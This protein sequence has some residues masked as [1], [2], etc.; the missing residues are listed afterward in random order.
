MDRAALSPGMLWALRWPLA[1]LAVG[2]ALVWPGWPWWLLM[3]LTLVAEPLAWAWAGRTDEDDVPSRQTAIL[4]A[5]A[6][7]FASLGGGAVLGAW[8]N[9]LMGAPWSVRLGW[10]VLAVIGGWLIAQGPARGPG[11]TAG[12]A[13]LSAAVY[14]SAF[15]AGAALGQGA[16]GVFWAALHGS[17]LAL[18]WGWAVSAATWSARQMAPLSQPWMLAALFFVA[19][20]ALAGFAFVGETPLMAAAQLPGVSQPTPS[21]YPDLARTLTAIAQGALTETQAPP[22]SPTPQPSPSPTPA[23]TETPTPTM[24]AVSPTPEWM[25]WPT[26]TPLPTWPP[27]PVQTGYGVVRAPEDWGGAAIRAEPGL[28]FDVL[29]YVPNGTML[30]VFRYRVVP[31][32]VWLKVRD[33]EETWEGWILSDLVE[34]ATPSP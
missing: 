16:W 26:P 5:A 8:V 21:P 10:W 14:G 29:R 18:L 15:L 24:A 30:K 22:P 11:W 12:V 31:P 25:N 4:L 34:V 2:L 1:W 3:A 20:V 28:E 7:W 13:A 17:V 6:F 32:H 19:T 33:L 9:G 27:P 23:P